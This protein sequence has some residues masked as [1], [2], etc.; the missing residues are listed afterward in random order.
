MLN[1]INSNIIEHRNG[2]IVIHPLQDKLLEGFNISLPG[3]IS[4]ASYLIAAAVMIDCQLGQ[5]T[6]AFAHDCLVI[7]CAFAC[8]Y[9]IRLS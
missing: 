8:N 6:H 2:E 9:H 1:E 7:Y 5:F 3:D 4:S